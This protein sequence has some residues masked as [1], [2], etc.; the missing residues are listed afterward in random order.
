MRFEAGD[1]TLPRRRAR[2]PVAGGVPELESWLDVVD[3]EDF[4]VPSLVWFGVGVL[5]C[6]LAM[7]AAAWVG[8][9]W[10]LDRVFGE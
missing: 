3:E 8:L 1:L 2:R 9:A 6:A 7:A 5:S 4:R 10:W